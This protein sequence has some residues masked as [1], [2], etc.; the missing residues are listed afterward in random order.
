MRS[1]RLWLIG[2]LVGDMSYIKNCAIGGP[3]IL[4][5]EHFVAGCFF[6]NGGFV[7]LRNGERYPERKE[8][9]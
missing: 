8:L 5:D 7:V 6:L 3:V 1:I 9:T 4:R 2:F